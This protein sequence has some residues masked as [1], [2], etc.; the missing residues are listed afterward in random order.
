LWAEGILCTLLQY[1][2]AHLVADEHICV[3]VTTECGML[4]H[5]QEGFRN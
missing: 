3:S 2:I 1:K 4:M 5:P